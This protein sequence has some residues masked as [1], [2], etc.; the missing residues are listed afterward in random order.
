MGWRWESLRERGLN[1]L[2]EWSFE[3]SGEKER[4]PFETHQLVKGTEISHP[5]PGREQLQIKGTE[6]PGLIDH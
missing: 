5:G 1:S 6:R 3:W 4:A 2:T